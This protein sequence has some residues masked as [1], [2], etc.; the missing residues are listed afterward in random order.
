[1]LSCTGKATITG[2]PIAVGRQFRDWTAAYA[3]QV[4][5]G[6][7]MN[8]DNLLEVATKVC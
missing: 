1:M 5:W 3:Y 4:F 8:T 6:N 2:M 7:R